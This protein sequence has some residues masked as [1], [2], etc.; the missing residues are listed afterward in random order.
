MTIRF[1]DK[2]TIWAN[3]LGR[4]VALAIMIT[5]PSLTYAQ[6][7]QRIAAIINNDIISSQDLNERM[8]I[9][10]ISSGLPDTIEAR[11]QLFPQVLQSY[12]DDT[13]KIQE[14]ERLGFEVTQADLDTAFATLASNNDVSV[15]QLRRYLLQND[16]D[17]EA[18]DQQL[19]AQI[20]WS[21]IIN[22]RIRPQVV[23][24]EDQVN[25]AVEA[26]ANTVDEELLLSEIV[27]PIYSPE[28]E[29]EVLRSASDIATQVDS[30]D[31]FAQ[32]ARQVSASPS[33][34]QGGNLGWVP[35]SLLIE[36]LRDPIMQLRVGDISPPIRTQAGVNLY[37]LRDR[38]VTSEAMPSDR[39]NL[40]QLVFNLPPEAGESEIEQ[41]QAAASNLRD[42]IDNCEDMTAAAE[43][44]GYMEAVQLGWTFPQDLPPQIVG[45]VEALPVS[46]I[47]APIRGPGAIYLLMV[48]DRESGDANQAL[49]NEVRARLENDVL[50]R[51]ANRYLRDLRKDAFIDVRV[52]T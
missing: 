9:V 29:V 18:L 19:R 45:T 36:G 3:V 52:R 25:F 49:R 43:S 39:V 7:A 1:D 41:M 10:L 33:A 4:L 46:Q 34:A 12:I 51:Q 5:V 17:L 38:R 32:I 20:A 11:Q 30:P 16:I 14:A 48:C 42:G 44:V 35:S 47:S 24:T 6:S 31:T 27:L 37:M 2:G 8:K 13:L 23:V 26:G 15:D 28:N 40:A 50:E 22:L 21:T